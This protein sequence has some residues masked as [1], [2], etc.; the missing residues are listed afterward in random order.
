MAD[1]TERWSQQTWWHPVVRTAALLV[2]LLTGA[3]LYPVRDDVTSATAV[4]TFVVGVVAAATTGDRLAGVIAAVSSAVWFDFFLTVPHLSFTIASADD[5]EATL[6]LV[7]I[8]LAVTEVSLWG[9]RQRRQA[10]RRSGYLDGVV[11]AAR[12]VVDGALRAD[13]V[14]DLVAQHIA[15]VLDVDDCRYVA[16]PV[17]DARVA[18]LHHDGVLTRDDHAVDVDRNGLPTDEYV[19]VPVRRGDRASGTSC[20][21]GPRGAPTPVASSAGSRCCS[22]TRSPR[23][24]RREPREGPRR[25]A[26]GSV[27]RSGTLTACSCCASPHPAT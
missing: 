1:M 24:A 17:H 18:I 8:S 25:V 15:D 12:A 4:L 13:A 10:A 20:S 5:V 23:S 14:N 6:L 22:P 11:V 19:A 16:G 7:A 21:P 9:S 26:P 3:L 27:A 2:P